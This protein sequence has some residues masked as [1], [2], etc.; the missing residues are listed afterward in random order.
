MR[1]FTKTQQEP[2]SISQNFS[3]N[4]IELDVSSEITTE[5][6]NKS[7]TTEDSHHG[8][9]LAENALEVLSNSELLQRKD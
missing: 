8:T 1:K 5:G 2:P 4:L 9:V 7:Q 6:A 3:N